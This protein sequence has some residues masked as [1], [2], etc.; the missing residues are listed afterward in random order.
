MRDHQLEPALFDL[1]IRA[2]GKA[3]RLVQV[4]ELHGTHAGGHAIEEV[5]PLLR[6][7]I[8]PEFLELQ[9]A[10][11]PSRPG[12]FHRLKHRGRRQ[13]GIR[14]DARTQDPGVG[15]LP[16]DDPGIAIEQILLQV[17]QEL[18]AGNALECKM[19]EIAAQERI[20]TFTAEFGVQIIQEQPALFIGN[21]GEPSVRIAIAQ[22]DGQHLIGGFEFRQIGPQGL[23]PE[24]RFHG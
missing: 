15:L 16:G 10:G 22:I 21:L 20:E 12:L 7:P 24:H 19:I 23:Q 6:H 11:E 1:S 9:L 5:Q 17:G 18:F 14:R 3:E 4:R 2:L 8:E 13:H